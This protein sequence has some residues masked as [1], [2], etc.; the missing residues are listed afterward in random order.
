MRKVLT[1][2]FGFVAISLILAGCR[3]DDLAESEEKM[4]FRYNESAG[5]SFLDPALATR[6]EDY[7][8]MSQLF[9]GLV[10]FDKDLNVVPCIAK[11]WTISDDKLEYTF[12][13]RNDVFFHDHELF[14][15][16]K[17]RKVVAQDF[18][19]SFFR[20][21]DPEVASPGKYIFQHLDRSAR[22]YGLG[23]YAPNDSILKI[24]LAQP[25]YSFLEQLSLPFCYVV[26]IEIVDYYGDDFTRNP[27]GTGPFVFRSWREDVK[28]VMVKNDNYFEYDQE[29]N[30]LPYL[31]AIAISFIREKDVEFRDFKKGKFEFISGL[32]P[33]YQDQLLTQTGELKEEYKGKFVLQRHPWLKTDYV[34]FLMKS[35]QPIFENSPLRMKQVRRAINYAINRR[36]LVT[37]LRNGIGHPAENGFVPMGMPG[38]KYTSVQGYTFDLE[39]SRELLFE[40]GITE[41]RDLEPITLVATNEYKQ[42]CE[43]LK[44]N[45]EETGLR[46]NLEIVV[47]NVHKQMIAGFKTNCF[48]KSWT[49]DYPDAINF[50]Q[51]F[52][53]KNESP[54]GPNYTHFKNGPFDVN[55]EKSLIEQNDTIR[56]ALFRNMENILLEEAPVIPLYYDEVVRFLQTYVK[57]LEVNAMNQLDLKRVKLE[58]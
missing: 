57:G 7:W 25:Q 1:G 47:P 12:T 49:A 37:Y 32:H 40:A 53:S 21:T 27:V 20:V 55:F 29:G 3:E 36:E 45:I 30:R 16:G 43:Y 54:H 28:L 14:E 9:N 41:P 17:G 4:V 56:Y 51:L 24:V 42:I 26:P 19:N 11:S 52:Y 31:D 8:A 46:V 38:Y 10:Q 58:K 22:S 50:L 23:F 2:L 13:L 18:V 35:D 15:G 34:G 39:K 6:F 44:S 48:R 33:S 5:I